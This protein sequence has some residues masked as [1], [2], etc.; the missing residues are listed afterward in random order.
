MSKK[1]NFWDEYDKKNK[2]SK[3]QRKA[4]VAMFEYFL[5]NPEVELTKLGKGIKWWESER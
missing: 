4:R 2:T 5:N 1:F 3:A